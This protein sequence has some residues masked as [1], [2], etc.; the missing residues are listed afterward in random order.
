MT[1]SRETVVGAYRLISRFPAMMSAYV[2]ETDTAVGERHVQLL[3]RLPERAAPNIALAALMAW[4]ES[5]RTDFSASVPKRVATGKQLPATVAGRL[6]V[7]IEVDFR[8]TPLQ[9]AIEFIGADEYVEVTPNHLRLRKN[10][11]NATAR[12]RAAVT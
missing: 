1:I 4:D 7:K 6:G 3:T 10:I 5:T 2:L 11:L 12:K 8:R 9:E